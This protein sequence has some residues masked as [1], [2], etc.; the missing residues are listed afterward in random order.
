MPRGRG[1]EASST[2]LAVIVGRPV[3]GTPLDDGPDTVRAA[4]TGP[5][6]GMGRLLR[7]EP[8]PARAAR[9]APSADAPAPGGGEGLARPGPGPV[10]RGRLLA[11][12][13]PAVA[14]PGPARHARLRVPL[15]RAAHR[16]PD[17]TAAR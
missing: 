7:C 8:R 16:R 11:T 15:V 3:H 9:S 13:E 2:N 10:R 17:R 12:V 4:D 5:G 6:S 14:V 1:H